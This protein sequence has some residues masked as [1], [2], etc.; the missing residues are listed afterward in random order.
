[1]NFIKEFRAKYRSS[2]SSKV[3]VYLGYNT[4]PGSPPPCPNLGTDMVWIGTDRHKLHLF[5]ADEPEKQEE[6]A[7]TTVSDVIMHIKYHCDNVFVALANGTLCVY[8]KNPIDG[9]WMIQEPQ[10]ITL[11][12]E[13]VASLLPINFCLYAACGKKVWVLNGVTAEIQKNF[14][15]HH[16]QFGNVNLMAHSGIGLWISQK[17][18]STI[19]LYHTETFKHL[20]DINIASIVMRGCG[21]TGKLRLFI[22]YFLLMF[23]TFLG[24]R[25]SI[26]NNR[27]VVFV[28]SLLACKGLLWVGTNVG[29]VLTIPLPRLEGVPIISGRVNISYH[30]HFGPISFLLALQPKSNSNGLSKLASRDSKEELKESESL[31]LDNTFVEKTEESPRPKMEKQ[32]SDSSVQS[33][34]SAKLKYLTNSPVVLRKRKSKD[35]DLTSR[36][37]KTLPRGKNIVNMEEIL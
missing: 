28:T 7:T 30:A 2:S 4:I 35:S 6:I 13:P 18:S 27:S 32:L 22:F 33:S 16:E 8:R 21:G 36:M 15:I 37:S 26:N 31:S 20:Q 9:A 3:V 25:D 17:N 34:V 14:M 29:R 19:C 11:G 10:M 12:T 24:S 5:A 1:M 23:L